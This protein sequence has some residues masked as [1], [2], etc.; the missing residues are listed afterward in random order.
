VPVVRVGA[1]HGAR[2][3]LEEDSRDDE[4]R[5]AMHLGFGRII[6]SEIEAPNILVSLV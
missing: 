5:L 2:A 3:L 6:V 4:A 1:L